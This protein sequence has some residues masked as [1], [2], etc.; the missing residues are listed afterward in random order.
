MVHLITGKAGSGK[1]TRILDL[2]SDSENSSEII[3]I[4][5]D[6]FSFEFERNL[7]NRLGLARFNAGNISVCG[8]GKLADMI[9]EMTMSS[10]K[11]V[12]S[13]EI[14]SILMY[15]TLK[16]LLS[17]HQLKFYNRQAGR[18]GFRKLAVEI[19]KELSD[20]GITAENLANKFSLS[21]DGENGNKTS[22]TQKMSD[23]AIIASNYTNLLWSSG[24]KDDTTAYFEAATTAINENYFAGKMIFIDGFSGF[25]A[26]EFAIIESIIKT[27]K[28]LFIALT[29]A[30]EESPVT[31]LSLFYPTEITKSKI[32]TYTRA[33]GIDY[34]EIFLSH[35]YRFNSEALSF[36]SENVL[37]FSDRK[38][39]GENRA[40]KVYECSDC[41]DEVKTCGA[42]V[43]KL[44]VSDKIYRFS[45]IV[46][47]VHDAR[48]YSGIISG[49]FSRFHIPV[50]IDEKHSLSHQSITIFFLSFLR[51]ACL[52]NAETDDYIKLLKTGFF[53]YRDKD[54]ILTELSETDVYEFDD[55][56]YRNDIR[57]AHFYEK[58]DDEKFENIRLLLRKKADSFRKISEGKSG[59]EIIENLAKVIAEFEIP[60]RLSNFNAT[61][62]EALFLQ[63]EMTGAWN[64]ICHVIEKI[65]ECLSN[66][67]EISLNEFYELVESAIGEQTLSAPPQTLDSVSVVPAASARLNNPKCVIILGANADVIPAAPSR[68]SLL[69]DTDI[70]L[71]RDI[72]I[73]I[74]GSDLE[75]I[76]EERFAIYNICSSPRERLYLFYRASDSSGKELSPSEIIDNAVSAFGN[77]ILI[78]S[79][80]I[81]RDSFCRTPEISYIDYMDN[82]YEN[83][84]FVFTLKNALSLK[85]EF[86]ERI[87]LKNREM[88]I[89]QP[90]S[91]SLYT[92]TLK[93]SAT[94]F[95]D[96]CKCPFLFFSKTT[97]SLKKREKNELNA[98]LK[99]N[100]VHEIL[101]RITCDIID[102]NLSLDHTDE[103]YRAVKKHMDELADD[104]KFTGKKRFRTSL[105]EAE[106]EKL[107]SVLCAVTKN[108]LEEFSVSDFKPVETE[109]RFGFDSEKESDPAF[110][111]QLNNGKTAIF[112]GAVDRVDTYRN[113][114]RIVDYKT[115]SKDFDYKT[116][117]DGIGLQPLI[118]MFAITDENA[119][120]YSGY[121]PAGTLF[122]ITL[123]PQPEETDR[124]EISVSK[125]KRPVGAVTADVDVIMAMEPIGNGEKGKYIPV[126][127][128]KPKNG[129]RVL[130]ANSNV[131]TADEF[132]SIK[133]YFIEILNNV[134]DKIYSGKF[135]PNPIQSRKHPKAEDNDNPNDE[136]KD[137][138]PCKYCDFSSVCGNYPPVKRFRYY[139]AKDKKS[140]K[141]I[142]LSKANLD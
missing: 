2:I 3:V 110:K 117:A 1:S 39:S 14:K 107:Y 72:G 17:T 8:F 90:L 135:A 25:T 128:N 74:S 19:V 35:T 86:V 103:A 98:L 24:Y 96:Y 95:E 64:L 106:Y 87:K 127:F 114:L 33:K 136:S 112:R 7:Y 66:D 79:F 21:S 129:E 20:N 43:H 131:L 116:M 38:Y 58:F 122:F 68:N 88:D 27:C 139:T 94:S 82:V 59:K 9:S 140:G 109:F 40:V 57:G 4:V 52:K 83:S 49:T 70:T 73:K 78:H 12:A 18:N 113:H 56:C 125:L 115:G 105:F 50:F 67:E 76:S 141:E 36:Y 15:R 16:K 54:G 28:D 126:D 108:L 119:K 137:D 92:D 31:E 102:G 5:P 93:L 61:D 34:E 63:R 124:D 41:Y 104:E 69:S 75:K 97:L 120:K 101:S 37:T 51:I 130:S 123:D 53:R 89:S 47:A 48:T 55:Y 60:V 71:L 134:A 22:L 10:Y 132:E 45:D 46:I 11:R 30:R 121:S 65:H 85:E 42:L 13:D 84:D 100:I 62:S 6:Q 81:K 23:I 142:L 133:T 29:Y 26:G 99:G 44:C 77:D 91:E 118:Y 111:I 138:L 32:V 80:N